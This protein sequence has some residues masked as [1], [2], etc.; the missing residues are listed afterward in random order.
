[1][2]PREIEEIKEL[3]ADDDYRD[4]MECSWDGRAE[5]LMKHIDSQE[6]ELRALR[7]VAKAKDRTRN[8][9]GIFYSD[10]LKATDAL[11]NAVQRGVYDSRSIVGDETLR[12]RGALEQF[13]DL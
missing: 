2:S 12:L 3:L 7:E 5:K 4:C 11:F 6:S 1:M 10:V 13:K 8:E 9:A